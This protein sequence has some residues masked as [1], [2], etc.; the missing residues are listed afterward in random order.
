MLFGIYD[1]R[2]YS[3]ST[4]E[5]RLMFK[6][7]HTPAVS[8]ILH[9]TEAKAGASQ[10]L[11]TRGPDLKL[12][13]WSGHLHGFGQTVLLRPHYWFEFALCSPEVTGHVLTLYNKTANK[14]TKKPLY[15]W[16]ARETLQKMYC[17]L[18]FFFF[19]D[20]ISDGFGNC[21]R[22]QSC[23]AVMQLWSKTSSYTSCEQA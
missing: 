18:F 8:L 7:C 19:L 5:I 12:T 9:W 13:M 20:V 23:L 22:R 16:K 15:L 11:D 21:L 10:E 6:T 3:G 1:K 17:C 2:N 4:T 14:Q